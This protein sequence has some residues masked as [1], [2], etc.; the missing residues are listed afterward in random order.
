[1][2]VGVESVAFDI[3]ARVAELA[4]RLHVPVVTSFMGRGLLADSDV[5]VVGTYLGLTAHPGRRPSGRGIRLPAALRRDDVRYQLRR[6]RGHGSTTA[7]HPASDRAVTMG[8]PSLREH[9]ARRARRR[10][11]ATRCRPV[12]A[13]RRPPTEYPRG[14]AP[15]TAD[16]ATLI[17]R[18]RSTTSLR[19]MAECRSPATAATACSLR[20]R[21]RTP[22]SSRPGYYATMGFGVPAAL[23]LQ[24]ATGQRPLVLV[25]DGA[26]QMTGWELGNCRRY[27]WDPIVIVMN[28]RS[29]EMLRVFQPESKFN[30]LDDWHFAELAGP[31]GGDGVRVST[32][33]ELSAA[34]ERAV[35]SPRQVPVDRGDDPV[36]RGL[37]DTRRLRRRPQ[38]SAA[39]GGRQARLSSEHRVQG[40]SAVSSRRSCSRDV[41]GF[42]VA[43]HSPVRSTRR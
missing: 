5:P 1:M 7:A 36:G 25:G 22:R 18:G 28:N 43:R 27:G 12:A 19:V 38:A 10:T 26:F 33:R 13:V 41:P 2:M 6:V 37:A 3:E 32:R 29:W 8:Y 39:E 40:A 17:S 34:L 42:R 24:A 30:T 20:S 31:L 14:L 23:G 35:R 11:R 15:T 4:R 21:S 16:R 9:P